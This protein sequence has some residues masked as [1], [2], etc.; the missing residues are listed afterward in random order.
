M[1]NN[2]NPG[3]TIVIFHIAPGGAKYT[4]DLIVS[5]PP[6]PAPQ[7]GTLNGKPRFF[8]HASNAQSYSTDMPYAID[9]SIV[10]KVIHRSKA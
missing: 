5:D 1:L 4:T 3:D 9:E 8:F 10:E 2:I 7:W 6:Y